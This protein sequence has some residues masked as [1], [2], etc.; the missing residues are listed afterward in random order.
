MSTSTCNSKG[1]FTL[2]PRSEF[3]AHSSCS[4]L[5]LV[6]VM[7]MRIESIHLRR[8]IGIE[9]QPNS[10]FIHQIM[11]KSSTV[12][13]PWTATLSKLSHL[14]C[15]TH[16]IPRSRYELWWPIMLGHYWLDAVGKETAYQVVLCSSSKFTF[17]VVYYQRQ[18]KAN[19]WTDLMCVSIHLECWLN[20]ARVEIIT[21]SA[22][23]VACQQQFSYNKILAM[24][25]RS[26]WIQFCIQC[27]LGEC[28]FNSH[29]NGIKCEK[30][31]SS[32]CPEMQYSTKRAQ[33]KANVKWVKFQNG[34][35]SLSYFFWP[36]FHRNKE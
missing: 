13:P 19:N 34:P 8:W 36:A 27:A 4:H 10:L 12:T 23:G 9:S 22:V 16:C 26:M 7:R 17:Y 11:I 18:G 20:K 35:I 2:D 3:N 6:W 30:A 24:W 28:E 33:K 5:N 15:H 29:S 32:A 1:L 21:W 25:M 31:L 14:G